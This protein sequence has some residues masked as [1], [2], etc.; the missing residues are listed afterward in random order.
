MKEDLRL[1]GP[2]RRGPFVPSPLYSVHGAPPAVVRLAANKEI[3]IV[4]QV[5]KWQN[6]SKLSEV[7]DK[8]WWLWKAVVVCGR[9]GGNPVKIRDKLVK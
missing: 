1:L 7:A 2:L 3:E 8:P 5:L 9:G 4:T 6:V